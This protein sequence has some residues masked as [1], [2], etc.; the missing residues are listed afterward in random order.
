MI[1]RCLYMPQL[2]YQKK[3][4]RDAITSNASYDVLTKK[5]KFCLNVDYDIFSVECSLSVVLPIKSTNEM[6]E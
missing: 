5:K 6:Y 4:L 1:K 3:K 2:L